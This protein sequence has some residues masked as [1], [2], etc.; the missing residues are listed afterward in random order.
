MSGAGAAGIAR[1]W[2]SLT[3]AVAGPLDRRL[4][5][6]PGQAERGGATVEFVILLP[7]FLIVFISS[8]EASLLL[9]R[10]VM[11]ERAVDLAIREVRLSTGSVVTQNHVRSRI[12][13]RARILPDCAASLVVEMTEVAAPAYAL[14]DAA[15]PCVNKATSVM[16]PAGFVGNRPGALIMLRACYAMSPMIPGSSLAMTRAL[17]SHLVND[18]DGSIRM[19]TAS[20][21]MVE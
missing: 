1:L 10:Q 5:G 4:P 15:A 7:A 18:E 6:G 12:C 16:P 17:A 19:V 11:L 20:A 3:A 14:P 2:S 21:F 8:V 9:V 13:E